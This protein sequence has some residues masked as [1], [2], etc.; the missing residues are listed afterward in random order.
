MAPEQ[1]AGSRDLTATADI[2]SLGCIAFELLTG[3]PP[4]TASNPM[5]VALKH[6]TEPVPLLP[7]PFVGSGIDELVQR[8]LAKAPEDRF[9]DAAALLEALDKEMAANRVASLPT[10]EAV[11]P[12]PAYVASDLEL[13]LE[14]R[15]TISLESVPAL[16][17]DALEAA[18]TFQMDLDP[19]QFA[20]LGARGGSGGFESESTVLLPD[21]G[22]AEDDAG[23]VSQASASS[24]SGDLPADGE[25]EP[26]V[27]LMAPAP[28]D[29][30][31]RVEHD[32]AGDDDEPTMVTSFDSMPTHPIDAK[33]PKPKPSLA[34][35]DDEPTKLSF[36]S[37]LQQAE[38]PRTLAYDIDDAPK[39]EP[40]RAGRAKHRLQPAAVEKR[41]EEP[42]RDAS[43]G[44]TAMSASPPSTPV[45]TK[46]SAEGA[47]AM[48]R[49]G[50][51]GSAA[52]VVAIVLLCL[53]GLAAVGVAAYFGADLLAPASEAST[54][55]LVSEP[56]GAVVVVD[57]QELGVTP[58]NLPV[59]RKS[60][61]VRKDGFTDAQR[62]LVGH[63]GE[64]LT[65]VL[66]P[67]E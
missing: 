62:D 18:P 15:S 44:P 50:G 8:A 32:L 46:T 35:D 65:V 57:G 16:V 58:L 38:S 21:S 37:P 7:A 23:E 6:M 11:A 26:T 39:S 10:S 17:V 28:S 45:S 19:A 30:F 3:A 1:A 49:R 25:A 5:T 59:S 43:P 41:R 31:P 40:A 20:S 4:F 52:F 27:L 51:G 33:L 66:D 36:A 60:V 63:G 42:Q 64:T 55:Y 54:V 22:S 2:Y 47:H 34:G 12:G 13:D 9:P 24:P 48:K 56:Q 67:A 61:L 53:G 14:H 29:L